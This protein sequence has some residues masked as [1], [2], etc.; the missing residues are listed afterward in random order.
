MTKSIN[1]RIKELHAEGKNVSEIKRI[2]SQELGRNIRYQRVYNVLLP[3][4]PRTNGGAER[5]GVSEEIKKM[6]EEGKSLKEICIALQVYPAQVYQ[7]K[8]RLSQEPKE[9][10][11]K[12]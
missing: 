10:E 9:E 8:K 1:S 6:L 12:E 11:I 4:G 2:L 7:V 5:R 3:L